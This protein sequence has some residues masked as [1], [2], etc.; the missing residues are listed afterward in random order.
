MIWS[1]V[2][3]L[4]TRELAQYLVGKRKAIEFIKPKYAVERQDSEDVRQKILSISYTDWKK[5]GWNAA[6]I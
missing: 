3:L 1:Y 4:K 2:L 5:M 6:V